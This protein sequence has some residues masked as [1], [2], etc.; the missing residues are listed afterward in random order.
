MNGLKL[1]LEN[2]QT[3]ETKELFEKLMKN[4]GRCFFKKGENKRAIGCFREVLAIY[5]DNLSVLALIV[6]WMLEILALN[7]DLLGWHRNS[8]EKLRR[9]LEDH[10]QGPRIGSWLWREKIH[11]VNGETRG[12]LPSRAEKAGCKAKADVFKNVRWSYGIPRR[13]KIS[14]K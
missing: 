13:S 5:P 4:A 14:K 2:E 3:E 6:S 8:G 7:F 10:C 11:R 9:G 12:T 1:F